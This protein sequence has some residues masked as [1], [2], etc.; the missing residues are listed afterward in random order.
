MKTVTRAVD[1]TPPGATIHLVST[2]IGG[3][4]LRAALQRAYARGVHVQVLTGR[5]RSQVMKALIKSLRTNVRS[6]SWACACL[7]A[8]VKSPQARVL[9]SIT[10]GTPGLRVD[11]DRPLVPRSKKGPMKATL[12]TTQRAYDVG[13]KRFFRAVGR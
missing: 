11:I 3:G 9:I 10:G 4:P 7:R 13:F 2:S 8:S 12:R 5:P 1:F 6:D